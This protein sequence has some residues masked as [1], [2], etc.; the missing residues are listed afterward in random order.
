MAG[1]GRIFKVSY[2]N[3][4]GESGIRTHGD[5]AATTVFKTVALN[6]SAISPDNFG[7]DMLNM[8]LF[9]RSIFT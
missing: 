2:A 5:I 6:R 8:A 7:G 1:I 4:C 9:R 3:M